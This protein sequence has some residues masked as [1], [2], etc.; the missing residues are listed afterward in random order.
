MRERRTAVCVIAAFTVFMAGAARAQVTPGDIPRTAEP[1]R[2]QQGL[3][4][5]PA[6]RATPRL[7]VPLLRQQVQPEAAAEAR[8]VFQSLAIEGASAIPDAELR[9][10]WPAKPGDTIAVSDVFG[11]ADA[12][13]RLYAARGYLLSFAL[14][15]E[16]AIG[17]GGVRIQVIEG[18][19]S[20]IRVKRRDGSMREIRSAADAAGEGL[21]VRTAARILESRPLKAG[22]LEQALLLL[23]DLPGLHATSELSPSPDTPGTSLLTIDLSHKAVAADA[24]YTNMMS[25]VLGRDMLGGGLVFSGDTGQVR[26]RGWAS[27][28]GGHYQAVAGE[29]SKWVGPHGLRFDGRVSLSWSRPMGALLETIRYRGETLN[30]DLGVA[31][32]LRRSR[33]G[34]VSL[35]LAGHVIDSDASVLGTSFT[36]DRLRTATLDLD[37]DWADAG[38]GIN[39]ARFGAVKG[40]AGLGATADDDPLRTR[41]GGS[42]EFLN[43][44]L[45]AQ[46]YQPVAQVAGGDFGLL[47]KGS[48][49]WAATDALLSAAECAY[50]GAS[51]GRS[52]DSGTVSADH[53]LMGGLEMRWRRVLRSSVGIGLHGFVDGGIGWQKGRLETGEARR[54]SASSAGGGASLQRG[55]RLTA[56]VEAARGL[57]GPTDRAWRANASL[58]LSL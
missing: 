42:A 1:S 22:D 56:M 32:P 21:A 39:I 49:Q 20:A 8:F 43:L 16:Q 36:R 3:D 33:A 11:F 38:G 27:P 41:L 40:L 9:A 58:S 6:A 52:Y 17:D 7:P 18:S 10:L 28:S 5:T 30:V 31:M 35:I 25:G 45:Y 14:V 44:T 23:N 29:A 26:L 19:V 13:T 48:G 51:F 24:T 2:P 37:A 15:P 54:H 50:G 53:G 46:R 55:P 47:A 4:E 34:N 12:V 57:S